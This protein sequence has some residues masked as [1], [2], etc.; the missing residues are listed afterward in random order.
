MGRLGCG[1]D[2]ATSIN[3][4]LNH[5][6]GTY[7]PTFPMEINIQ[8]TQLGKV[9]ASLKGEKPPGHYFGHLVLPFS[10]LVLWG[11][12]RSWITENSTRST[13]TWK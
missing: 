1:E 7:L 6:G 5:F 4:S 12:V 11:N 13:H 2:G 9:S 10:I 3:N 8:E